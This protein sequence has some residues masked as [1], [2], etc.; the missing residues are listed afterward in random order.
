MSDQL[1][2]LWHILQQTKLWAM[3][4]RYLYSWRSESREP[5]LWPHNGPLARYV[6]LR[7]AHAPGMPG[8]LSPP[9]GGSDADI[10]HGICVR[11]VPWCMPELLISGFVSSRW[12]GKRYRHSRCIHKP[13]FYVSG[14]RSTGSNVCVCLISIMNKGVYHTEVD[15]IYQTKNFWI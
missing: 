9:A 5:T 12:R 14:K 11:Q 3:Y 6:K 1:M 2:I 7:D 15:I 10:H 8:T 4:S 13:Q